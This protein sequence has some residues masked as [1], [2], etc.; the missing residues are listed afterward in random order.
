MIYIDNCQTPALK[1][2][3]FDI[4]IYIKKNTPKTFVKNS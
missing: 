4:G 2:K 1:F 3:E